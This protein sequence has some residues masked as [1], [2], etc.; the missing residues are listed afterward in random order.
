MP[1]AIKTCRV[2]GKEYEACHTAKSSSVTFRWQD[3]ACSP[4]CGAI[5]LA[6]IRASRKGNAAND[7]VTISSCDNEGESA[8]AAEPIQE[9]GKE[10]IKEEHYFYH[11]KKNKRF[12]K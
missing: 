9:D 4:E 2:C 1:K 8:C 7:T 10:E 3:V 12:R 11:T 6:E 5:Y